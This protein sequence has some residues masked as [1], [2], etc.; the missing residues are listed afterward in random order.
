MRLDRRRPRAPPGPGARL[1]RGS[2]GRA[3][4]GSLRP[5]R[6]VPGATRAS[7]RFF[8]CR[9]AAGLA[10]RQRCRPGCANRFGDGYRQPPSTGRRRQ[11]IHHDLVDSGHLLRRRGWHGGHRV[12]LIVFQ[13]RLPRRIACRF[14]ASPAGEE[15]GLEN[16][17]SVCGSLPVRRRRRRSQASISAADRRRGAVRELVLVLDGARR[18]GGRRR[19]DLDRVWRS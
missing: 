9:Q 7:S 12:L 8:R 16:S 11:L 19:G 4:P 15:P 3:P 1:R 14:S 2:I 13:K 5:S 18:A 10:C 17:I 6:Q